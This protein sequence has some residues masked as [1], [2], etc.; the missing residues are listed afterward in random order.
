MA[1]T[2]KQCLDNAK[3][4][5]GQLNVALSLDDQTMMNLLNYAIRDVVLRTLPYHLEF[6]E[7]DGFNILGATNKQ[8]PI[9]MLGSA[10]IRV[11]ATNPDT[12]TLVDARY[13]TPNEFYTAIIDSRNPPKNFSPIYTIW[14]DGTPHRRV[15]RI[16]PTTIVTCT[17]DIWQ[18]P[19]DLAI[20]TTD[21]STVVKVP[22]GWE[23]AVVMALVVKALTKLQEQDKMKRVQQQYEEEV[24][25]LLKQKMDQMQS[26]REQQTALLPIKEITE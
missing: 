16:L 8:F 19:A 5:V 23:I 22:A 7:V 18:A 20:D 3:I 15:F 10:P 24:G 6:Y 9:T 14:G 2:Q 11:N 4:R 26:V 17:A 13:A 21:Y 1:T 12:S 25:R